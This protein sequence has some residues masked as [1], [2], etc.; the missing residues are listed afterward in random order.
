MLTN[1]GVLEK[2]DAY[3]AQSPEW[4]DATRLIEELADHLENTEDEL[5]TFKQ[6]EE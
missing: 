4:N 2:A 3:L 1:K 5:N 6:K